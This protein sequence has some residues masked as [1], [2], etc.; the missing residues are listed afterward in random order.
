[1]GIDRG[2]GT[3]VHW[4]FRCRMNN[5]WTFFFL[6]VCA[7]TETERELVLMYWHPD[8]LII[9]WNEMFSHWSQMHVIV[10]GI[11]TM[12]HCGNEL[13]ITR[14]IR[15]QLHYRCPFCTP[16]CRSER[17]TQRWQLCYLRRGRSIPPDC[18]SAGRSVLLSWYFINLHQ[19]RRLCHGW[20]RGQRRALLS[21]QLR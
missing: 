2:R 11:Q 1:M 9:I 14:P 15:P 10:S 19:T 6:W 18:K 16:L 20:Q 8:Y 3:V 17:S 5:T 4:D 12:A 7:Y 13:L 21:S